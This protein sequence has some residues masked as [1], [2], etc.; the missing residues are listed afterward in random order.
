MHDEARKV[1]ERT[2]QNSLIE[3]TEAVSTSVASH[4]GT[5][6]YKKFDPWS[7][8]V[9]H[10]LGSPQYLYSAIFGMGRMPGWVMHVM[11][12]RERDTLLR[13]RGRYVGEKDRKFLHIDRR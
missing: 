4:V 7:G 13:P 12:Q 9:Y 6:V 3:T 1:A 5:L 10:M 11:E 2:G 8:A